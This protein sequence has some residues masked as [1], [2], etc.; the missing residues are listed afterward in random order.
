MPTMGRTWGWML[1]CSPPQEGNEDATPSYQ[2]S[3]P[4]ACG[5]N[6]P[7]VCEKMNNL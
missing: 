5:I 4:A 2:P 7:T 3:L 6:I 1:Y